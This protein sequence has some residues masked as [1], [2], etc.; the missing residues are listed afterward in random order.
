MDTSNTEICLEIIREQRHSFINHL[1]V[2]SGYLQLGRAEEA[3]TYINN[4][5]KDMAQLSQINRIKFPDLA[6]A[7]LYIISQGSKEGIETDLAVE[8]DFAGCGAPGSIIGQMTMGLFDC[9]LQSHLFAGIA[10]KSLKITIHTRREHNI[11][12]FAFPESDPAAIS[13]LTNLLTELD[14]RLKPYAIRQEQP[15]A[16]GLRRISLIFS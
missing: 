1:Q 14:A 8:S 7:L 4:T 5:A 16:A 9:L 10:K 11:C 2:I 6:L 15:P 12:E 3:K 13:A